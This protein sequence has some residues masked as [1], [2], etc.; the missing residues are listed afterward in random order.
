MAT[1]PDV[2]P[3]TLKFQLTV[4][5]VAQAISPAL[6]AL[7]VTR[8]RLIHSPNARSH[9][10]DT[11]HCTACGTLSTEGKESGRGRPGSVRLVRQHA[12]RKSSKPYV[13]ILRRSC[14][15]CSEHRDVPIEGDGA[16]GFVQVR[17]HQRQKQQ[18]EGSALLAISVSNPIS[19][20]ESVVALKRS[21]LEPSPLSSLSSTPRPGPSKSSTPQPPRPDSTRDEEPEPGFKDMVEGC[22]R[23]KERQARERAAAAAGSTGLAAFLQDL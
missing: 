19:S 3:A 5:V 4:P 15:V 16:D 23:N 21:P 13:R 9:T 11:T 20:A 6:A 14:E 22:T 10:F 1:E 12:P 2:H 17:K 8:F 7:H 18:E